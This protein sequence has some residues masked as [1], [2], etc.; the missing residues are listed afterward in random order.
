[1][2]ATDIGGGRTPGDGTNKLLMSKRRF[3]F[4]SVRARINRMV[5]HCV[6]PRPRL[7][8]PNAKH[9]W[10]VWMPWV[11]CPSVRQSGDV[12]ALEQPRGIQFGGEFNLQK[13]AQLVDM[14]VCLVCLVF[15][16]FSHPCALNRPLL[17][18]GRNNRKRTN[19]PAALLRA[20][21]G[22]FRHRGAG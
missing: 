8:C 13:F 16:F 21:T 9:P 19:T 17:L 10:H 6:C 14:M 18:F 3:L 11:L 22:K 2:S 15:V 1:M 5:L 4:S 12:L 20:W 7:A